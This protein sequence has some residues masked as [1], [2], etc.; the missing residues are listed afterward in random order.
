[1]PKYDVTVVPFDGNAFSIMGAVKTGMQKGGAS[2]DEIN[3]YMKD[4]MS[5]DYDH[6][7][8]VSLAMVNIATGDDDE[9]IEDDED[10]CDECGEEWEYCD[11]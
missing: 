6:L 8:Q 11:C 1:M 4:A 10:Y 9:D 5:G 7:L 2:K 3:A